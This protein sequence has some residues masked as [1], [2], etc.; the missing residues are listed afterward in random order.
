MKIYT[1]EPASYRAAA[2]G[3]LVRLEPLPGSHPPIV[4]R[5]K[6]DLLVRAVVEGARIHLSGETGTAKTLTIRTLL[7]RE[8]NFHNICEA[9]GHPRRPLR[10][11]SCAL[12]R[13]DGPAELTF[14]RGIKDNAT[15]DEDSLLVAALKEQD[16][17]A[18]QAYV[19][20]LLPELGR[21]QSELIQGALVELIGDT[22]LL[23]ADDRLLH[24][25]HVAWIADS[26][27]AG[28]GNFA[29]VPLD[30][31][32]RRRFDL[33]I[34]MGHPAEEQECAILEHLVPQAPADD[35]KAIV[36]LGSRIR[37]ARRDGGL[38]SVPPPTLFGYEQFLRTRLDLPH[39]PPDMVAFATVLGHCAED[40]R[41]LAADLL[42]RT[43]GVAAED[44]AEADAVMG[45]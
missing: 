4:E 9:L 7:L 14:R 2:A 45:L 38:L 29:L 10:I 25:P 34:E 35:V 17:Q 42:A 8:E 13:F 19:A 20:I 28:T 44:A 12:A 40:D 21:T 36:Q 5:Q 22:V 39:L 11:Y 41:A 30:D 6:L 18:G 27:Y 37:D 24:V 43:H 32:L 26:N 33:S 1:T 23:E 31:S 16:G 3:D 15:V